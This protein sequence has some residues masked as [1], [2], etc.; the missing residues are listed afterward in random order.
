MKQYFEGLKK[1]LL[2]PEMLGIYYVGTI[3]ICGM[4]L[5]VWDSSRQTPEMKEQNAHGLKCMSK[6]SGSQPQCWDQADWAA[7][8]ENT[9]ICKNATVK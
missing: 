2:A 5:I 3:A 8:C 9:N 6:S 7:F 4:A 1:Y